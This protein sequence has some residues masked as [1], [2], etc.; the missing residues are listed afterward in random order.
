MAWRHPERI[1][2]AGQPV[3]EHDFVD[4]VRPAV[5]ELSGQLDEHNF[6][7]TLQ[8]ELDEHDLPDDVPF[9]MLHYGL[10]RPDG[11]WDLRHDGDSTVDTSEIQG[12]P[13]STT[14]R[15][16][17]EAQTMTLTQRTRVELLGSALWWW[18]LNVL[19]SG[20]RGTDHPSATWTNYVE[21]QWAIRVDGAVYV[22]LA[23]GSQDYGE[24]AT[25]FTEKGYRGPF[26][27][28][29]V[30]SQL[31]LPAGQHVFELVYRTTD[32]PFQ[33]TFGNATQLNVS[34]LE[35]FIAAMER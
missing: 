22:E 24:E 32:D 13:F 14:W 31:E 17:G 7:G 25:R 20:P 33:T 10:S 34:S 2:K 12:Y 16:V 23:N 3:D 1:Q 15:L 21:T 28:A 11:I 30:E 26:N 5:E 6:A 19:A 29:T 27:S 9:R 18:G 4:M 8:G 35:L